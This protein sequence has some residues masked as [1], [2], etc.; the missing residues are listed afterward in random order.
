MKHA[1]FNLFS[2]SL[3]VFALALVPPV[4]C[5][6]VPL[7]IALDYADFKYDDKTN[8][9]EIYYSVNKKGMTYRKNDDGLFQSSVYVLVTLR[10]ADS[11]YDAK[12]WRMQTTES[13]T[14]EIDPTQSTLDCVK[15][16]AEPGQYTLYIKA[17][18]LFKTGNGDSLNLSIDVP[19]LGKNTFSM[20]DVQLAAN[21]RRSRENKDNPFYKNGLL[22]LPNPS[23]VYGPN[24]KYVF[25]Y[26]ELYNL[27]EKFT[28]ST[29]SIRYQVIMANGGQVN[30]VE[31]EI[32]NRKVHY[33]S[34]VEYG[35]LKVGDLPTGSYNFKL[36]VLNSESQTVREQ[37][38]KFYVYNPDKL[39]K[40]TSTMAIDEG[41]MF[42]ASEFVD[43]SETEVKAEFDKLVYLSIQEQRDAFKMLTSLEEKRKWLFDFWREKD[44]T[45]ETPQ[46]EYR[47]EY[48]SRIEYA[49]QHFKEM[50][51][52]G[53]KTDRGRVYILYGQ[54]DFI[55]RHPHEAGMSPYQ[56]WRYNNLQ[57]G[58]DFIFGDTQE[59]NEY[60]LLHSN[61]LGEVKDSDWK[62]KLKKGMSNY[63]L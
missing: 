11:L 28:D 18:D 20:S 31:P 16:L 48:Y 49:N 22:V 41:E 26:S 58:V 51:V 46:N 3:I 55:E 33:G 35:A 53:W 12:Q 7:K 62:N 29:Y 54:P 5:Q 1:R 30:G 57:S 13:D 9:L 56:I 60:M 47:A 24:N 40:E 45:P 43:M 23:R 25:F 50:G 52:D 61:L 34:A 39:P 59:N 14:A 10:R 21:V 17:E 2:F 37:E 19:V 15:L 36:E 27:P 6:S 63:N 42:Q 8:Y 32:R 44:T 4:L 38:E